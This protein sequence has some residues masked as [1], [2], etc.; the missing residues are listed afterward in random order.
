[1][2]LQPR[3]T[4][5]TK[6]LLEVH[7]ISLAL[8][9]R[10]ILHNV[11][12]KAYEGNIYGLFG[13]NGSGKTTLFNLLC[14]LNTPSSGWISYYG[15]QPAKID[16]LCIS[17]MKGGLARTF[18]VPIVVN[19]LPVIDNLLLAYRYPRE[20][21]STLLYKGPKLLSG[22]ARAKSEI[23]GY[24]ERFDLLDKGKLRCGELSYGERRL[25]SILTAI[26]TGARILLLDE[27]FANLNV[28]IIG[29]MKTLL[30]SITE[31][32]RRMVM[33]IEHLPDNMVGFADK[34][35]QLHS[36]GIETHDVNGKD[37]IVLKKII[38]GSAYNYE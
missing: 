20:G 17:R 26:L 8:G 37:S 7:Q 33:L 21:F 3:V 32:E 31:N 12:F 24:L 30:R 28:R 18:Q 6:V 1:M 35:F 34:L 25:V 11:N 15:E 16:P 5:T 19:D 9:D 4:V 14:G 23:M 22:E 2:D 13:P 27:P 38:I 10:S 29:K 36:H